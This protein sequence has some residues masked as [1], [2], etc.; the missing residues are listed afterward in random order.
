MS[1]WSDAFAEV[2]RRVQPDAEPVLTKGDGETPDRASELDAI[3]LSTLRP[4]WIAGHT[5]GYGDEVVLPAR[6][7][8]RYRCVIAGTSDSTQPAFSTVQ[9]GTT[10]D[11]GVVWLEVGVDYSSPY[12]TRRAI[13][14]CW[15]AKLAK[16]S[17]Y[18]GGS[19]SA[20]Y[21]NCAAQVKR[22]APV[23]IA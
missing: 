6:N 3:L 12:D 16:A 23:G 9:G 17:E 14:E 22:F 2:S 11:N 1:A 8:H 18:E 19:E 7:G 21:Q 15:E 4:V 13:R 20:I 5:Y 10:S